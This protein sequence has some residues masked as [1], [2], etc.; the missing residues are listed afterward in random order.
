MEWYTTS[1]LN[2]QHH[3]DVISFTR[4]VFDVDSDMIARVISGYINWAFPE[5]DTFM[6]CTVATDLTVRLGDLAICPCHRTAY[7]KYLYGYF[8]VENDKIVD[9]TANNPQMAIKVLMNNINLANFGCDQCLYNHYCL[10]GC[11]GS[12]IENTGDPWIP[13]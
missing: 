12:Q 3:G 5:T 4:E 2:V 7:D 6:G 13:V 8:V 11:C 10:K 1:Y 9:I